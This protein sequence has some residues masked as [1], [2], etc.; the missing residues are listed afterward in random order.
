[1]GA[2]DDGG[3]LEPIDRAPAARDARCTADHAPVRDSDRSPHAPLVERVRG[4]H[5][6]WDEFLCLHDRWWRARHA[7]RQLEIETQIA[8]PR[9]ALMDA[10]CDVVAPVHQPLPADDEWEEGILIPPGDRIRGQRVE[11]DGAGRHV[12]AHHLLPVEITDRPVIPEDPQDE[13]MVD[14]HQ[15]E[16]DIEL[17]AEVG[18]D[19]GIAGNEGRLV[20][21]IVARAVP[22]RNPRRNHRIPGL[23]NP[24]R[25]PC[26]HRSTSKLPPG[27][28][29]RPEPGSTTAAR[30]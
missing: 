25:D 26:H 12:R 3:G 28:S 10:D 17:H 9:R 1:M 27:R 29:V 22:A 7:R 14:R 5:V 30:P 2:G 19:P 23:P 18:R 4:E 8:T 11:G 15:A 6:G 24:C 13:L 20:A 16:V 21:L